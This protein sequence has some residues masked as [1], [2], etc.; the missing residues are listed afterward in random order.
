MSISI[1]VKCLCNKNSTFA[2]WVLP[3]CGRTANEDKTNFFRASKLHLSD[4]NFSNTLANKCLFSSLNVQL[5]QF[6]INK[7]AGR[8]F[9]VPRVNKTYRELERAIGQSLMPNGLTMQIYEIL[10]LNL[11]QDKTK[12]FFFHSYK[13]TYS[14]R[15]LCL[16]LSMF[17]IIVKYFQH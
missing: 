3:T 17:L 7:D 4:A 6:S 1:P 13:Q 16:Y 15:K 10:A 5:P 11:K 12:T 2:T 9:K 8:Y 14:V